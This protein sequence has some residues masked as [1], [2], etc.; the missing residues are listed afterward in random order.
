MNKKIQSFV[1]A[2][3]LLCALILSAYAEE[4]EP[5]PQDVSETEVTVQ[6]TQPDQETWESQETQGALESPPATTVPE[7]QATVGE[8]VPT[9]QA[10]S[11]VLLQEALTLDVQRQYPEM[12][13]SYQAGYCGTVANGRLRLVIPFL[14]MGAF[15]GTIDVT[16]SAGFL[17]ADEKRGTLF[18]QTVILENEQVVE[19]VF[20]VDF[21]ISIPDF[22]S[23]GS[24]P[25][26]VT[27][28]SSDSTQFIQMQLPTKV[29]IPEPTS[30]LDE[31]T[32]PTDSSI[33]TDSAN[34]TAPT[35]SDTPT[36]STAPTDPTEPTAPAEPTLPTEPSTP[37][38]PSMPQIPT[39]LEID[40]AHSYSGMDMAYENGY[41]P[42]IADGVMKVVLPLR[43]SGAMWGDKLE[44]S[45]SLD[46]SAA[47]PFV[48]E[49]LRK[50]FYLQSVVPIDDGEAQDIYLISFDI[51][52]TD[53]RKNGTYPVT[54]NTSG[55]DMAGSPV[56]T[57]FTLY[58]TITDGVVEKIAQPTVDTPTAEP[59]VYVSKTVIEPKTAQAGEAFTMTVTL[60][61]SITTKSVRNML[62]TVDTGNVQINL[63]EDSSIFPVEAIDRGGEATLILHFSTEPAIPSGK[64]PIRFSFK[65][66][67]S[68]TL[69]LSST[70]AAIVEIQQPANMELVMPR[71]PNSVSVGETIPMS[72]QVMNMGRSAMYNV[73]CVVS[74]FGF[75]PSNTGYIG[76]MEAGTSK[77]TKVELY[78]IALNAS[79]GNE[80]GPQYGNT[81]GTVTLLYEDETGQEYSQE[82]IFDTTVNRPVVQ[83][84]QNNTE[85]EKAQQRVSSWWVS[86]SILGGVILAAV[87]TILLFQKKKHR[88]G[89]Y[90]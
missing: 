30:P 55:F 76:T 72:F 6:E 78:I 58:I 1:L 48:V 62:V 10:V 64:Y 70:G 2:L 16:L 19:N 3:G 23:P 11:T 41:L 17:A 49:N 87:G 40:S 56:N 60:K 74:G 28:E 36:E 34:P 24:Y 20:L 43:C 18:C 75:V 54:I 9:E 26:M 15:P 51:P 66:D 21:D 5:I 79:T 38:E 84:P 46:T 81:T 42:R 77:N 14:N 69:N 25:V 65:Y 50:N 35:D 67:S 4:L 22:V 31:S 52:L 13:R 86:V 83:L 32:A 73:R 53:T 39:V 47:S 44:A 7:P 68:K 63:D 57:S 90:L 88:G 45:V 82:A 61:N 29:V 89:N 71:F 85:E 59:V 27:V 12:D 8:E 37:T 80:N 33:P